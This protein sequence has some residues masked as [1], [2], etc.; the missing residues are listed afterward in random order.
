MK[1]SAFCSIATNTCIDETFSFLLSLSIHHPNAKMYLMTDTE[2]KNKIENF[3]TPKL[4]LRIT[5]IIELDGYSNKDRTIMTREGVW[6]KFMLKKAEIIEKVLKYE[7]DVLLLDTDIIILNEINDIDTTKD[8]GVSPAYIKEVN[9]KEV[10]YYNGGMLWVQ[11]KNVPQKWV[12]LTKTSRYF[13]QASID[14]LVQQFTFFEFGEN[15]NYQSWRFILSICDSDEQQKSFFECK[16]KNI[17]HKDAKL[18]SIHTHFLDKR[19]QNFNNF[20]INLL[21]IADKYNELLCIHKIINNGFWKIKIPQ[22]PRNNI[23]NHANDSYRELLMMYKKDV[24]LETSECDNILFS[25]LVALYDRP[26]LIWLNDEVKNANLCL[27]GNGDI[28]EEGKHLQKF[29]DTK[30]WIFWPRNPKIFEDFMS[31]NNNDK[32]RL[33]ESVFIGNYENSVQEKYRISNNNNLKWEDVVEK[34]HITKGTCH[35]FSPEQYMSALQ[36]SKFGLCLRGFGSKCHRE[37]ECMG[38]GTVPI[39]TPNVC[40]SSYIDPPV[41]NKHFVYVEKPED[42]E[43]T[44]RSISSEKWHEM[45]RNCKEWYMKNVHSTNSWETTISHII[46]SI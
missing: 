1:P 27:L 39:I 22:Q 2:T 43:R 32:E 44:L 23:Y 30:P 14:D 16:D 45:S 34:F 15:H 35:K 13:E 6:T 3:Y 38:L 36:E 25:D 20:I 17:Y 5:W 31:K 11:N 19:M 9:M 10:G 46:Y 21:K 24:K 37:V 26:T 18:I 4:N 28:N 7:K 33:I 41:V 12:E 40:I 42:L 8:I 29:V